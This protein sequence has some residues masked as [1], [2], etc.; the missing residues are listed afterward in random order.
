MEVYRKESLNSAKEHRASN[1][2]TPAMLFFFFFSGLCTV[3]IF[4]Y[5]PTLLF[6]NSILFCNKPFQQ[7][8][9]EEKS[10]VH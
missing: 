9:V 3:L 6:A 8:Y 10:T 1:W 7:Q 4:N 2:N 5:L